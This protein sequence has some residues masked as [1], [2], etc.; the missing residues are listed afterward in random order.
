MTAEARRQPVIVVAGPTAS[1]KSA[2]AADIADAVG[3]V[4]INADSMQIYRGL[5]V[6]SAA[7]GAA[8]RAR[9]PHRLYGVLDPAEPCSAGWWRARAMAEI[10]AARGG[11]R[12]AVLCGGTGLYLRA[13]MTGLAHLPPVPRDVRDAVRARLARLGP[14]PLHAE[15]AGRDPVSAARIEPTD[16][17]RVARALEVLEATGRPLSDWQRAQTPA[18]DTRQLAFFTILLLPPRPA[19][20][21]TIDARFAA[22]VGDGGLD[23]V[24]ALLAGGLDPALPAMKAL[25]VPDLIAHL[26]GTISL[27]DAVRRG[28]Q[29]TRRYA[30]R[31]FTWFRNQIIA[32]LTENEQYSERKWV[33]IFS[34]ISKFLL[35]C[36]R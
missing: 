10:A 7:P 21:A 3:G 34:L 33:K 17:Q 15:L 20:Y 18:P 27:D 4:V 5:E 19:L 36:H 9:V 12:P 24:R 16:A 31:Q 23:E 32:N 30:K 8:A 13:L 25:G 14:A 22:M 1:G 11:G 28:Q 6:L 35:T 2:L 29:G 26:G